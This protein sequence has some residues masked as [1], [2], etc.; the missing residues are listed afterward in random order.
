MKIIVVGTHDT[1]GEELLFVKRRIESKGHEAITIDCGIMG[2]PGFEPGISR[3]EVA[4]A[5]RRDVQQDE[6]RMLLQ[7]EQ[8]SRR[9]WQKKIR[10]SP[11]AL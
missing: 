6:H 10:T 8:L 11:S 1:K 9:Y 3:Q 4:S 2:Q 5:D 7:Q